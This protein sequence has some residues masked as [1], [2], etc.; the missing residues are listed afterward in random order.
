MIWCKLCNSQFV[1]NEGD[2]CRSCKEDKARGYRILSISGHSPR[3]I[4]HAVKIGEYAALCGSKPGRR[5]I[6][7]CQRNI[8]DSVTC[9]R[10]LAKIEK[11]KG[12]TNEQ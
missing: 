4:Y 11:M 6:G 12:G 7:W 1:E 10:C 3:R 2:I 5:S 9:P 8:T